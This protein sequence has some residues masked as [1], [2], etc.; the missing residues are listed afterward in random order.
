MF[1]SVII[2]TQNHVKALS[3][4]LKAFNYQ[5]DK[6]FEVIVT[7]TCKDSALKAVISQL[8][9]NSNFQ[10]SYLK[11]D[12]KNECLNEAVAKAK[13]DYLI[14][15]E[16]HTL[17][18][19][20]FIKHTKAKA[21][22]GKIQR[23]KNILVAHTLSSFALDNQTLISNYSKLKLLVNRLKG[24]LKVQTVNPQALPYAVFKD[25]FDKLENMPSYQNNQA[26]CYKLSI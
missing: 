11:K 1:V 23:S 4:V 7:D 17:F 15:I 19:K 9:L 3:L 13:G 8:I 12:D 21:L 25:N 24:V 5:S 26:L 16:D 10:L 6:E 20:D 14:F 22:K 2:N 18:D